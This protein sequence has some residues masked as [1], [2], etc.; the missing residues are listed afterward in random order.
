MRKR[1]QLE[2]K[3]IKF[4]RIS[5]KIKNTKLHEKLDKGNN[6]EKSR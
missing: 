3:R 6:K 1:W 4:E 2:V 5:E